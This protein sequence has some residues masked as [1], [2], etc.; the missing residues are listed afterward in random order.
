MKIRIDDTKEVRY[1]FRFSSSLDVYE[2]MKEYAKADRELFMVMYLTAQNQVVDCELHTIGSVNTSAVYLGEVFRGA[3]LAN[4][5]S[6]ICVH[7]HPSG[8]CEPSKGDN[9]ITKSLVHAGCLLQI[10]VLDHVI[11][12]NG[13]YYSYGDQGLMGDY[14][15]E[16]KRSLSL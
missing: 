4:A 5:S 8:E 2:K 12:G 15:A 6:I 9:E 3:L 14:E 11:I 16:A 1:N 7:N 13:Q 10:K